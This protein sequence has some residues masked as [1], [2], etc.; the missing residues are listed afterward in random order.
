MALCNLKTFLVKLILVLVIVTNLHQLKVSASPS[1]LFFDAIANFFKPNRQPS[2]GSS[3]YG[4]PKPSYNAPSTSS[5]GAPKPS[6][7]AP[8][9]SYNPPS[10][11]TYGAPKP[12]YN[13]AGPIS[14]GAPKPSYNAPSS[15]HFNRYD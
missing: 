5:Y 14:Y 4:A 1:P 10:S 12:S 11:S 2:G 3:S 13:P 8:K 15:S 9:P 7:N 6:Y